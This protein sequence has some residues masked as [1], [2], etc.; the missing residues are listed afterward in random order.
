VNCH[1]EPCP[2]SRKSLAGCP[3]QCE[4]RWLAIRCRVGQESYVHASKRKIKGQPHF[5]FPEPT[6]TQPNETTRVRMA[7]NGYPFDKMVREHRRRR[8]F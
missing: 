8:N 3:D 4:C 1:R 6:L 5:R 2:V 7:L